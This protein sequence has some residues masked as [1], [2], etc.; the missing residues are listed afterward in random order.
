MKKYMTSAQKKKS[1]SAGWLK[2]LSERISIKLTMEFFVYMSVLYIFLLF[3]RMLI[4]P[5]FTY[6]DF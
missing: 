5:N 1:S 6:A 3:G 4:S 2:W